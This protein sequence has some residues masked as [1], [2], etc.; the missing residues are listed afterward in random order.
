PMVVIRAHWR[1]GSAS[2]PEQLTGVTA[3]MADMLTEGAGPYDA[4]AYKERLEELNVS[5]SFRA[6]WDGVGMSLTTLSENLDE[7]IEM[8]RLAIHQPRFDAAPLERIKRQALVGIRQRETNPGYIAGVALE[9]ALYSGHPY[10]RRT[11]RESI[12]AIDRR[13]LA[14]RHSALLNRATLQV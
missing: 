3:V 14:E 8:A 2:E 13:S 4:N 9:E 6:G 5:L 7:A 11:S 12:T 10:A 1:G